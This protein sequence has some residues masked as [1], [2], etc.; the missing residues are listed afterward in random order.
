MKKNIFTLKIYKNFFTSIQEVEAERS[1][2]WGMPRLNVK[3]L[4]KKT[5]MKYDNL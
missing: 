4:Y 3:A 2:L 5:K 1:Q